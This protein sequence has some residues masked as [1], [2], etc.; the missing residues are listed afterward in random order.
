MNDC[1]YEQRIKQATSAIGVLY[2]ACF[3]S[4]M[5]VAGDNGEL[6]FAW[7]PMLLSALGLY[8]ISWRRS[9]LTY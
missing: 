5:G 6:I 8:R 7:D 3:G 1:L 2:P 9:A 4:R